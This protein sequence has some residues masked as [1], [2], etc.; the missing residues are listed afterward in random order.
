MVRL[1][2]FPRVNS[3][4]FYQPDCLVVRLRKALYHSQYQGLCSKA[5][6]N[7]TCQNFPYI[8]YNKTQICFWI[9]WLELF[10]WAQNR[11]IANLKY[12]THPRGDLTQQV[13]KKE[14]SLTLSPMSVDHDHMNHWREGTCLIFFSLYS[15]VSHWF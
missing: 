5:S 15:L 9:I 1:N 11:E 12:D 14:M 4:I 3:I 7:E 8:P 6:S 2:V 13:N 10:L